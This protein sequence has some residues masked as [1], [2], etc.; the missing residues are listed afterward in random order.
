MGHNETIDLGAWS[1][2]SIDI[3]LSTARPLSPGQRI[4]LISERFIGTPYRESTLLGDEKAEERLVINLASLDCFTFLDTVEA[5]RR[6]HTFHEFK[7]NMR[8]VRYRSGAVDY[9]T[10]NH[11][12]TDWIGQH[13]LYLTDVTAHIGG[14]VVRTVRKNL[15]RKDDGTAFVPG[16]PPLSRDITYLPANALSRVVATLQ[17]GDYIGVYSPVDG[18]DV[19]HTG[20]VIEVSTGFMLRHASSQESWRQVV[21]QDLLAYLDN[22][23]GIVV[24]RPR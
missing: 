21:D 23:P 13:R 4:A 19:S 18:L 17:T 9:S 7:A 14:E 11:F 8:L 6:S 20:I 10:R 3:L 1:Q 22:K 16:I 2:E 12:F 5:M 15:N 24:L